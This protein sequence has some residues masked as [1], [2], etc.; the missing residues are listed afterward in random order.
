MWKAIKKSVILYRYVKS[1]DYDRVTFGGGM[2][3]IHS[4]AEPLIPL[5]LRH[6]LGVL[7]PHP[8][9]ETPK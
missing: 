7:P 3:G 1:V 4:F 5:E 8:P 6:I 9:L 2:R